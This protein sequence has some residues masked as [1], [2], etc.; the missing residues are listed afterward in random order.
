MSTLH[1]DSVACF[2]H[3]PTHAWSEMM[4]T[5]QYLT[6]GIMFSAIPEECVGHSSVSESP[7][8]GKGQTATES[9]SLCYPCKG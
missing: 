6:S 1:L 9:G 2:H 8:G 4:L 3:L 5:K 7:R